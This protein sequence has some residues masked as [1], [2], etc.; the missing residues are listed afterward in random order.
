MAAVVCVPGPAEPFQA[1]DIQGQE[2]GADGD[3]KVEITQ[4]DNPAGN[5]LKT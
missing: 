1:I 5:R 4:V 2:D 3:V